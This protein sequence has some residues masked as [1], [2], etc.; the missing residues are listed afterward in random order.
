VPLDAYPRWVAI[1]MAKGLTISLENPEA[2][3]AIV[4]RDPWLG[5]RAIFSSVP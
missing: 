1:G 3:S 5:Q 4:L 2:C